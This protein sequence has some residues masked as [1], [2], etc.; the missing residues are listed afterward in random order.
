M[1]VVEDDPTIR[2]ALV[3]LLA[4]EGWHVEDVADG[5]TARTRLLAED[6]YDVVL[7]DLHLPGVSGLDIFRE[8]TAARPCL[9][10]RFVFATGESAGDGELDVIRELRCEVLS[11]PFPMTTLRAALKR[12]IESPDVA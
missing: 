2:T 5:A 8:T 11:K 4:L 7:C 12:V 6:G 3:R 10:Q 9:A 1:L